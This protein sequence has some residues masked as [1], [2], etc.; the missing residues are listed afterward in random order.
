[1]TEFSFLGELSISKKCC[2]KY[3]PVLGKYGQA[4][5]LGCFQEPN[6][7]IARLVPEPNLLGFNPKAGSKQPNHCAC[8]Y[9]TQCW[10][11]FNP[12]LF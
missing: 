7:P 5:Q 6:N 2:V 4:Q 12:A 10:V 1:M 9:F 11:V 3:S 8:P